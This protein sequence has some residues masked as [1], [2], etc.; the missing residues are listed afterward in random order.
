MDLGRGWELNN[1]MWRWDQQEGVHEDMI[2]SGENLHAFT[3]TMST[4]D[5]VLNFLNTDIQHACEKAVILPLI[6]PK[7][8]SQVAPVQLQVTTTAEAVGT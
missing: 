5:Q 3:V 8:L 2:I 1:L 4:A 7:N 6:S